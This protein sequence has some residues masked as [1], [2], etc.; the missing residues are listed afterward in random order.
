[1]DGTRI[2]TKSKG[3]I[4]MKIAI[5]YAGHSFHHEFLNNEKYH[6]LFDA[7]IYLLDLPEADLTSYDILIVPARTNQEFLYENRHQ[8]LDFLENGKWLISFGEIYRPWLPDSGWEFCK[9]NFNWWIKEGGGLPL[10]APDPSH[11]L[12][13]YIKVDDARWHYHGVFYP[14]EGSRVILENE[15]G[16]AIIYEDNIN[17][18]GK[19]IATT[20]DPIYHIGAGFIPKVGTF[21]DG[22]LKWIKAEYEKC[23]VIR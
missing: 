14:P 20:L 12:F 16:E 17:Y 9:T 13:Q 8:L 2:S 18:P 7:V 19:L 6:S 22:F 11:P 10:N 1:M 23:H 3:V 4:L 5:L 21:F 15:K